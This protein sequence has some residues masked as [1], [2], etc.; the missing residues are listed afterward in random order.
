MIPTMYANIKTSFMDKSSFDWVNFSK[1]SSDKKTC[2]YVITFA[3][4]DKWQY[5]IL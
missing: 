2:F 4:F 5:A 3:E 1:F